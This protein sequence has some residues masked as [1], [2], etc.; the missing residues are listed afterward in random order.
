MDGPKSQIFTRWSESEQGWEIP[1]ENDTQSSETVKRDSPIVSWKK[2]MD[3]SMIFLVI[4]TV[5]AEYDMIKFVRMCS[6]FFNITTLITFMERHLPTN[7]S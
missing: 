2:R 5:H 1:G 7:F 3:I 4:K 6:Q